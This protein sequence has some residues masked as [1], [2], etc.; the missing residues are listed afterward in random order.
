M[1]ASAFGFKKGS[2]PLNADFGGGGR[3]GR[4]D[5]DR[6]FQRDRK[7]SNSSSRDRSRGYKNTNE[8]AAA[9]FF[10][11]ESRGLK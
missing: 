9:N 7:R 2:Q 8:L 11:Y 10:N 6:D 4:M 1:G 3:G 5:H